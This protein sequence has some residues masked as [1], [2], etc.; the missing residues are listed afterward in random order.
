V[1]VQRRALLDEERPDR[2]LKH[3]GCL[4]A[5]SIGAC[6]RCQAATCKHAWVCHGAF[7]CLLFKA[8]GAS[9]PW[10]ASGTPCGSAG[11]TTDQFN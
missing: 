8:Q 10:I 3:L 9:S 5:A 7:S 4:H 1:A 2:N 11:S 6:R